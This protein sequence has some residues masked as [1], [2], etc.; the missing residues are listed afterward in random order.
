M[1]SRLFSLPTLLACA[2]ALFFLTPG[3]RAE[4]PEASGVQVQVSQ[5]VIR[6]QVTQ[7]TPLRVVLEELCRKTAV[8]CEGLEGVEGVVAPLQMK[9][10]WAEVIGWLL[11]GTKLNYVA[12]APSALGPGRL[13]ILGRRAALPA[14]AP[15]GN[16]QPGSRE[17]V[18]EAAESSTMGIPATSNSSEP[19]REEQDRSGTM[20]GRAAATPPS[21]APPADTASN[22]PTG[23]SSREMVAPTEEAAP[24]APNVPLP[25]FMGGPI[26]PPVVLPGPPVSPFPDV[27]G[28]PVPMVPQPPPTVSVFPDQQGRAVPLQRLPPGQRPGS[29]FPPQLSG[30]R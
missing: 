24:P 10:S 28:N 2:L 7:A 5:G 15:A 27:H 16:N 12:Q 1:P 29:P 26:V 18:T 17:A 14:R 23:Q 6:L 25:G 13:L 22:A 30:P 11:E 21:P 9:G 3:M 8:Q 19:G 4:V 20:E